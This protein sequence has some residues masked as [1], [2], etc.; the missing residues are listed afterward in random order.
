MSRKGFSQNF[1]KRFSHLLPELVIRTR[2]VRWWNTS[3]TTSLKVFI[4]SFRVGLSHRCEVAC[5]VAATTATI[6]YLI[7]FFNKTIFVPK[8]SNPDDK[9]GNNFFNFFHSRR[10]NLVGTESGATD[11]K[12]VQHFWSLVSWSQIGKLSRFFFKLFQIFDE[13]SFSAKSVSIKCQLCWAG[14]WG[15]LTLFFEY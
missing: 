1:L 12:S 9:F 10:Q 14:I 8:V 2:I 15:G 7:S 6:K 4:E 13:G 11:N 3:V 5:C